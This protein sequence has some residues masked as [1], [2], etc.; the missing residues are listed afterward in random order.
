MYIC[1]CCTVQLHG[2][3]YRY[4]GGMYEYICA[5]CTVQ[6]H[7]TEMACT[8]AS[9]QFVQLHGIHRWHVR[10]H[11]CIFYNCTVLRWHVHFH[12]SRDYTTV[13]VLEIGRSFFQLLSPCVSQSLAGFFCWITRYLESLVTIPMNYHCPKTKKLFV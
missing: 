1:A 7:G 12:S 13:H 8:H 5:S 3:Q 4:T 11:L 6:L 10:V 9:V 2:I